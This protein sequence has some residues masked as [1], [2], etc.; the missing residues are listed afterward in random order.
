ML[1]YKNRTMNNVQ[2]L[3]LIA[4]FEKGELTALTKDC[5][6]VLLCMELH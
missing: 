3:G 4:E 5:G 2:K 6:I 1:L